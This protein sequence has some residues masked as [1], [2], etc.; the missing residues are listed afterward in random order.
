MLPDTLQY[1]DQTADT[2]STTYSLEKTVGNIKYYSAPSP[3][4]DV[5]GRPTLV[6]TQSKSQKGIL[7][8]TMK[9]VDP[10][11]DATLA[12]YPRHRTEIRTFLFD[13]LD[14]VSAIA[15]TTHGR[16][17]TLSGLSLAGSTVPNAID[18]ALA[19]KML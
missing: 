18:A 3:Q 17:L 11:Y 5:A 4:G 16:D 1:S 2:S 6:I 12:S 8:L 15:T 9:F 13:E 10:V 14:D 19:D 7:N